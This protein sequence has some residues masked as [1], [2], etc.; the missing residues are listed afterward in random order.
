MLPPN[1]IHD[2]HL[3]GIPVAPH[4]AERLQ[5]I[6]WENRQVDEFPGGIQLLEFPL[7]YPGTP[8][9]TSAQSA[10]GCR[11]FSRY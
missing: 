11:G 8:T 2:L 3:V 9:P 5:T 4:E 1:D 10:W 7:G 6:P